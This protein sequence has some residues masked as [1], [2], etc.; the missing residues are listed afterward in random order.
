MQQISSQRHF[1][2]QYSGSMIGLGFDSHR[3]QLGM[4][5]GTPKGWVAWHTSLPGVRVAPRLGQSSRPKDG[6]GGF[7]GSFENSYISENP[8][9][10][11]IFYISQTRLIHVDCHSSMYRETG[12][13]C[14]MGPFKRLILLPLN[15]KVVSHSHSQ[16]SSGGILSSITYGANEIACSVRASIT[17]QTKKNRGSRV[18]SDL[19][20]GIG[21]PSSSS[22]TETTQDGS[23]VKDDGGG[24]SD[25]VNRKL[26]FRKDQR[27]ES[28]MVHM[29]ELINLP[30]DARPLLVFINKKSG[31][32]RGDS[33]RLRMNILL[34]PVQVQNDSILHLS[35]D[36][37][38]T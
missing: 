15:V 9:T 38:Y 16:P 20:K 37:Y 7:L 23:N 22:S 35:V 1:L 29:Y 14:D 19:D 32:K 27:D 10:S 3:F 36:V 30:P 4:T 34:N 21:E 28:Q 18:S 2:L 11:P 24:D 33:I 12:D 5:T 13:I 25:M 8:K 31:A 17:S 26:T 6:S